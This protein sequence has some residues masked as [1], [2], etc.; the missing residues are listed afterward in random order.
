MHDKF[1]KLAIE[2][3]KKGKL[4][5]F[6]NPLVGAVIVKNG[7]VIAKGAHLEYGQDHA[8]RHAISRCNYP[9]ELSNSTMYVTLE[10][11]AH[12]GKQPPCAQLIVESGIKTVV[13]GQLD[14]NPLV[15]GKGMAY[16]KDNGVEVIYG[17]KE[18]EVRKLNLNYNFFYEHQRPYIVLKQAMT[19]DGKITTNN[20]ERMAITGSEV[21]NK[22]H[23]E[24]GDYHG[25]VVG[26]QTVLTDNPTLL[27]TQKSK[28]PPLRII[29]D[30]RGRTLNKDLKLFKEDTSP[31]WIF[32]ENTN[33]LSL[34]PHVEVIQRTSF[35]IKD[36]IKEITN[37]NVQSLY[38]EGGARIHDAFLEN[39]LWDEIITYIAPKILGGNSLASFQSERGVNQSIELDFTDI[40]SIGEDLRI[41]SKRKEDICSQD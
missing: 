38:I 13:I 16:L 4:N 15:Q 30:R 20:Q 29:I 22:V 33:S 5:T 26:S 8:E 19:I 40:R 36:V 14:P 21:W 34:P 23:E 1:M 32:T 24:R 6:T 2:E 28:F 37:R 3:A 27:S 35:S 39:D 41:R 31:V 10:P 25:I 12:V 18:N 17:I 11:C 7:H 9:E